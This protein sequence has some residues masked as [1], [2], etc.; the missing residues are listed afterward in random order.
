M[1]GVLTVLRKFGRCGPGR[2]GL[3]HT[4][5]M[6]VC[7]Q[8]IRRGAMAMSTRQAEFRAAYR[9]QIAPAYHGLIHV[10]LIY[11]IG[12]SALWYAAQHIHAATLAECAVVP[13]V[14]V[15]ANMFEWFLH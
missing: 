14:V 15:L 3:K 5:D 2:V 7:G 8:Q 12:G 4:T 6:L 13:A 9:A 10:A 11:L 1:L